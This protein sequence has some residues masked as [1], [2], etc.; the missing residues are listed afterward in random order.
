[1]DHYTRFSA[2]ASLGAVGMQ[3]QR[4]GLWKSVGKQVQIKQKVIKHTPLEKLLDAFINILAGGHGL[5]EVN[6]RVK[7][8]EALQRAFGRDGCADQS[9]I[10]DTL[11]ACT[12]EN[13]EQMRQSLAEIYRSY[14]RGYRHIY[15]EQEQVLDVDMTGMPAGRQGEGVEKGYFSGKKNCR[16]RQLGRVVATLYDE[17]V[18]ERLYPG[19]RQLERSL[20]ELVRAA[21]QVLALS[22]ARRRYTIVRADGGAGRD[23]DINWLLNRGYLVLIKVKNWKRA[24]KLAQSVRTWYQDPKTGDREIG[25]VEAPHAYDQPTRQVALRMPR[26]DGGYHYRVLVFNLSDCQLFG[27]ARQDLPPASNSTPV[28]FA[29]LYAYDL[30]SG[31]VETSVKGSKQ[32]L[33]LT[34][35]N[36]K[37]FT[38]QEMLVLLAQLAYNLIIWTRNLLAG[39]SPKLR[40]FGL[41]RMVRDVFHIDGRVEIDAQGHILKIILNQADEL[42]QPFV[43]GLAPSWAHNET[44]LSLGQN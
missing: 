24:Q 18:V 4:M 44:C 1:M 42:A 13:V 32:G 15:R 43:N 8:D 12:E 20:Q 10:S 36:K 41:L 7:R 2:R 26:K 34:K 28:L 16:G 31:G 22:E 40:R 23:A 17:I 6:K 5:V 35:R 37:R 14:G 38:A 3:M 39:P 29:A 25:L 27:L 30:R 9:T 11:N 33:G 19:K 21:E